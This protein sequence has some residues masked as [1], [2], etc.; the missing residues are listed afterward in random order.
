MR[1]L[2]VSG[3]A[4]IGVLASIEEAQRR[5]HDVALLL[6]EPLRGAIDPVLQRLHE[7]ERLLQNPSLVASRLGRWMGAARLLL[8]AYLGSPRALSGLALH[9]EFRREHG[10]ASA[11]LLAWLSLAERRLRTQ[12]GWG[13]IHVHDGAPARR[14]ALLKALGLWSGRLVVS[15]KGLDVTTF[16]PERL[17]ERYETLFE[18][19]DVLFANSTFVARRLRAAGAPSGKIHVAHSPV[20]PERI[21]AHESRSP[22]ERADMGVLQLL[23]VGRLVELKGTRYALDALELLVERGVDA[24]LSIY[25]EGPLRQQLTR[26]ASER[27]LPVT[28]FGRRPLGEVYAAMATHDILVFPSIT[29]ENGAAEAMGLASLEAQLAGMPVVVTDSGGLPE[30]VVDG[31]SGM[32][33]PERNA[34]A[35]ADA[36]EALSAR[37]ESWP[38]MAR[39][40]REHVEAHFSARASG[41]KY[42]AA[43]RGDSIPDDGER[44]EPPMT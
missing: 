28:W 22:A 33:V 17:Q 18:Q 40:G 15:F 11:R 23:L 30:T 39:C 38:A 31:Q 5:G 37:R 9:P 29:L 27:G 43:Y 13:A 3:I 6:E 34:I 32:V 7:D 36:I 44:S 41:A 35:L 2:F 16:S 14:V 21:T 1:I 42:D 19:A 4:N 20:D 26:E 10:V 12:E 24:T 25:G 8:A